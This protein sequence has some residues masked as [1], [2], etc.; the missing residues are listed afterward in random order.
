MRLRNRIVNPIVSGL[1]RSP[2][3]GLLSSSLLVLS[4]TGRRSGRR[5]SLPVMYVRTGDRLLV[6]A[7]HPERKRWW[8]NLRDGAP[9][10]VRLKRRELPAWGRVAS[11]RK[12]IERGLALYLERFPRA[13][14]ALDG[15][16][17]EPILVVL[18]LPR[19]EASSRS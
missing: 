5:H 16:A 17:A 1:L 9:V 8:H 6:F 2:L 10:E 13:A 14:E 15:A 3:H 7:A 4:Y 11:S 12:E 19:E 18:E